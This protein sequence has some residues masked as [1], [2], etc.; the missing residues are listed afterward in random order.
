VVVKAQVHTGGRGKAGGVKVANDAADARQHASRILGMSIKDLPVNKVF[1]TPAADI[2]S[3]AYVGVIVDRASK[4][5]VFMV[6]PA[7]GVDIEDVAAKTPEL[8]LRVSVDPRYGLLPFQASQLGFFLSRDHKQARA[9]ARIMMQLYNAF[10]ASG[11]SL[12]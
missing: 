5:A 12:A 3:E 1:V 8:I 11:A 7:G 6:S 4:G 2:A 9:C 10:I